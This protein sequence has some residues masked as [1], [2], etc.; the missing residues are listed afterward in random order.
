MADQGTLFIDEIGEMS[1]LIQTK[2]LRVLQEQRFMRVGG[3]A[4]IVPVPAYRRDQPGFMERS[5]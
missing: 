2:L 4:E 5:P 1:P 3:T